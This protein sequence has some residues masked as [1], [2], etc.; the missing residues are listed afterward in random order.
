M[1]AGAA[2]SGPATAELV[3]FAAI[4]FPVRFGAAAWEKAVPA[5]GAFV[6]PRSFAEAN[7]RAAGLAWGDAGPPLTGVVVDS[8]EFPSSVP[9][10]PVK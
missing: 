6:A 2:R 1:G 5:V 9:I 4:E 7:F 8:A 3:G 10:V